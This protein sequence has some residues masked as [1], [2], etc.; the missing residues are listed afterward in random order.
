MPAKITLDVS[1]G[2]SA[3]EVEDLRF[4]LVDAL[5]EFASR[6]SPPE[7]YVIKRYTNAFSPNETLKKIEQVRR[8]IALARKLHNP[9][10]AVSVQDVPIPSETSPMPVMEYYASCPDDDVQAMTAVLHVLPASDFVRGE[11]AGWRV[12]RDGDT[13]VL[14]G[15]EAQQ[16]WWDPATSCWNWGPKVVVS[17]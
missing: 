1:E 10:L 12:W 5:G 11:R 14:G 9:A 15:P 7:L 17:Q 8:R 16:A 3:Q 4:L 13:L 6:R 2:L